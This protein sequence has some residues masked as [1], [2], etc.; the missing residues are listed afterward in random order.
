MPAKQGAASISDARKLGRYFDALI[1]DPSWLKR[2]VETIHILDE[3]R[4]ERKVTLDIDLALLRTAAKSSGL[5]STDF[6]PIP[7]LTLKK[8]LQLDLD[9]RNASGEPL[10]AYVSDED[11]HVAHAYVLAVLERNKIDISKLPIKVTER[12]WDICRR[13]N[14]TPLLLDVARQVRGESWRS[15]VPY[16]APLDE[17]EKDAWRDILVNHGTESGQLIRELAGNYF[18]IVE[19]P[20]GNNSTASTALVKYRR[21]DERRP[22]RKSVARFVSKLGWTPARV[23]CPAPGIGAAERTHTR[24]VAPDG[25][26][27]RDIRLLHANASTVVPTSGY[28]RRLDLSRGVIYTR[29]RQRDL[30]WIDVSLRPR[31]G[32]FLMPALLSTGALAILFLL[33]LA[34]EVFGQKLSDAN[35]SADAAVAVI[36]LIPSL[37]AVELVRRDEHRVV[38]EM[39]ALPRIAV[40]FTVIS[41]VALAG[42][43]ASGLGSGA[44][45]SVAT[46]ASAIAALTTGYLATLNIRGRYSAKS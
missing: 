1:K 43:V 38:G 29:F 33:A 2:R 14:A 31:R 20:S 32:G 35:T 7:L 19:I 3:R 24:V 41:A 40:V 22:G 17:P 16:S 39:L 15:H 46:V 37:L 18:L 26:T 21:V 9:I 45:I 8:E 10:A 11:A 6:L 12:L 42:T 36:A 13:E 27:I 5:G 30:F 34:L 44:I 25:V 4:L 28:Q 23:L